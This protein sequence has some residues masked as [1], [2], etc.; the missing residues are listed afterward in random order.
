MGLRKKEVEK[1]AAFHRRQLRKLLGIRW[2]QKISNRALYKITGTTNLETF[3][4]TARMKM[5]GHTLRLD[6]ATP[7]QQAMDLYFSAGR[8]PR[9]HPRACLASAVAEDFS[10][11]GLRFRTAND[12]ARARQIAADRDRWRGLV[13]SLATKVPSRR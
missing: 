4:T 6:P 11:L 3:V 1:A 13:A 10:K 12:L 5:L 7:A 9:G 8:R 2:P